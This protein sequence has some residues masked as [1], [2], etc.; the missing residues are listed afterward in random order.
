MSGTATLPDGLELSWLELVEE[1]G[2]DAP[3]MMESESRVIVPKRGKSLLNEDGTMDVAIIRPCVSRGRRIKGL[4]PIYEPKMLE[5]NAKVFSGWP[6]YMDH[7]A[8]QVLEEEEALIAAL[9]ESGNDHLLHRLQEARRITELGG[10]VVKSWWDP[11]LT[12]ED[13]AEYGYQPGG[14]RGKIIPQPQ[15]LKMLEADP[16]LLHLS[17]NAWPK[18]ARLSRASWD[19]NTRGMA[20]EGIRDKPIG[21]VDFVFRGGAGGRPLAPSLAERAV[22]ILERAYSSPQR[23]TEAPTTHMDLTKIKSPEDLRE[24]LSEEAPH[25]LAA[26]DS[27][28]NGGGDGSGEGKGKGSKVTEGDTSQFVTREDLDS[29]IERLGTQ[30]TESLDERE[31]R[32]KATATSTVQERE[33]Q[34]RLEGIARDAIAEAEKNGL[35][36]AYAD[37]LRARYALL[38]SGPSSGLLVE[39]ETDESGSVKRSAEDVLK[40]RVRE[41]VK[42][43][44]K[45]IE[46]AGGTARVKGLGPNDADP[47]GSGAENGD[48]GGSTPAVNEREVQSTG[49]GQLVKEGDERYGIKT[50]G[51]SAPLSEKE[52]E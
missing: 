16:E 35:P 12:F 48:G 25:L 8:E 18:G 49:L 47:N 4:P 26:L 52:D 45:L 43:C 50:P 41:D 36:G 44:A 19:E 31:E 39:A 38:P 11:E 5:A 24:A 17:I 14:V 37:D 21:S 42:H 30:I 51:I 29:A 32:A 27:N 34:R 33:E 20:I 1:A 2:E 3:P 6:M 28:G 13:D 23:D 10:R 15:P 7:L 22:S 40:E 9:A 46:A